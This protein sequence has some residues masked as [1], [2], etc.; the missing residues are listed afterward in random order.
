MDGV[1]ASV[2]VKGY[3]LCISRFRENI[4]AMNSIV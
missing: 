2:G 4:D 1:V 3:R